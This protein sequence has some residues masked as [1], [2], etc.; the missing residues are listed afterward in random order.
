MHISSVDSIHTVDSRP[1]IHVVVRFDSQICLPQS[2][3][4]FTDVIKIPLFYSFFYPLEGALFHSPTLSLC[5]ATVFLQPW[6]KHEL[7]T[8]ITP[9]VREMCAKRWIARKPKCTICLTTYDGNRDTMA[10]GTMDAGERASSCHQ[11]SWELEYL[12]QTLKELACPGRPLLCFVSMS[13]RSVIHNIHVSH[14]EKEK[15]R[16][17]A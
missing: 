15:L 13:Q 8:I 17:T 6:L 12:K 14:P 5:T 2:P 9:I 7:R 3:A 10:G 16:L 1:R 4:D 11:L